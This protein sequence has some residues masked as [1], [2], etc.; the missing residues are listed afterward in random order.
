MPSKPFLGFDAPTGNSRFDAASAARSPAP[1]VVIPFVGVQLIGP[2]PRSPW[3]SGTQ[4]WDRVEQSFKH[5][6]VVG[7]GS[8]QEHSQREAV[9]IHH[10][11][12]F[13]ARFAS[14]CGIGACEVPPFTARTL[15]ESRETRL[16]STAFNA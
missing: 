9:P 7:V 11:M 8:G 14:V 12:A 4:G 13:G 3:F 10:D 16:Q 15:A 6:A 1:G 2:P 5:H